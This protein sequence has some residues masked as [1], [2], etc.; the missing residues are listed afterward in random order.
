MFSPVSLCWPLVAGADIAEES[1]PDLPLFLLSPEAL[2]ELLPEAL[3]ELL[4]EDL[5]ELLPE[6]LA[7]LLSEDLAELLSEDFVAEPS[8]PPW[9]PL[10]PF[11]VALAL[12]FALAELDVFTPV[13]LEPDLDTPPPVLVSPL[14][15]LLPPPL[16][17]EWVP[18]PVPPPPLP[19]SPLPS[20][21]PPMCW[22]SFAV[23]LSWRFET[24]E[25]LV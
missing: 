1:P 18:L 15:W 3:A 6:A 2:A 5:A 19:R 11:P 12:P 23:G 16:D 14:V 21:P 10:S 20:P 13:S 24:A 8:L 17:F 22:S 9:T 4:T 7:E 25:A